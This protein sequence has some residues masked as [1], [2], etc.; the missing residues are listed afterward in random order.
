MIRTV[1]LLAAALVCATPFAAQAADGAPA[2]PPRKREVTVK[3]EIVRIGDLIE[4]A[5]VVADVPIFRAPD[6]GQT[7]SVPAARVIDAVRPHHILWLD[8]GG[9][10]EVVV[11]R[12]SRTVDAKEIEGRVI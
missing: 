4:N 8:T 6:I 1:T 5:G 7:G 9:L 10:D 3:G 12:A 11:T 2:G